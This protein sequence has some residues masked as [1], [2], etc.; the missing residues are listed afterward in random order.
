MF[1]NRMLAVAA[2]LVMAVPALGAATPIVVPPVPEQLVEG[3]TVFTV[4][5]IVAATATNETRFAAAVAVLVREY[6]ADN[7]AQR[8]PGV[9]WFNDQYLVNPEQNVQNRANFRYPC[10]GAVIAV[11]AGDPDPRVVIAQVSTPRVQ[12]DLPDGVDDRTGDLNVGGI[13][14]VT[15]GDDNQAYNQPPWAQPSSPGPYTYNNDY[16]WIGMDGGT[17]NLTN[18]SFTGSVYS[19]TVLGATLGGI[20][21]FLFNATPPWDYRESYL[22]T[23]P[24]D[25]SW[26]IDKYEFYTRDSTDQSQTV[27]NAFTKFDDVNETSDG[28]LPDEHYP[29]G[30]D[31]NGLLETVYSYPVWV[32]NILG[33]PVFF[34]DHAAVLTTPL[35]NC[36]PYK[37]LVENLEESVDRTGERATGQSLPVPNKEDATCGVGG[38]TGLPPYTDDPCAGYMEPSRNGY[39]YGGQSAAEG[40]YHGPT[41]NCNYNTN[42]RRVNEAP[43]VDRCVGGPE[44]VNT[45]L[46][47]Y[48]ALLYFKLEDLRIAGDPR[49]HSLGSTDTNG[50]AEEQY[51]WMR[52]S[53]PPQHAYDWPCPGGDDNAEG[54]S[55]PFHPAY[56]ADHVAESECNPAFAG[57][58]PTNHGGST[59]VPADGRAYYDTRS[60][61]SW[62]QVAAPCDYLHATRNIDV[63][64]SGAGRPFVP[65]VRNFVLIDL[66]GSSAPFQDYHCAY[67]GTCG[68][69]NL[70][71]P[72]GAGP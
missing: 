26:I 27:D 65:I 18:P 54:N 39:C 23:D 30:T 66:E 57:P 52:Q 28:F 8:F 9:L 20:D 53:Q 40:C 16:A 71:D 38:S 14:P 62:Y 68:E 37:D 6:Q 19:D 22:I 60:G 67:E 34:P 50:C 3:H 15:Y 49:D 12:A 17:L 36:S 13:G 7:R 46:R 43:E 41:G 69:D 56:P 48:N 64:F 61:E 47:Q 32:V 42:Y 2:V 4:I 59:Y 29:T 58:N 21:G 31:P 72:N 70:E 11:N 10:G 33:S 63:Y 35:D 55:H 44:Y 25:H 5:E 45:P 1:N 51:G 24:N